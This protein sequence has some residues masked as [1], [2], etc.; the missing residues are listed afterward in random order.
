MIAQITVYPSRRY[1]IELVAS[2]ATAWVIIGLVVRVI[3]NRFVRR[4]VS[5]GAWI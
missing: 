3:S 5:W 2:L 1:L 4:V